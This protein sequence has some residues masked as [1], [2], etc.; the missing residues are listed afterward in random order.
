MFDNV[1]KNNYRN[2]S[3][4]IRENEFTFIYASDHHKLQLIN[5]LI[6][7]REKPDSGTITRERRENFTR[8]KKGG[9]QVVYRDQVLLLS[10]T[11]ADNLKFIKHILYISGEK[12]KRDIEEILK[13]VELDFWSHKKPSAL[14]THQLL[15]LQLARSL[16]FDPSFLILLDPTRKLSEINLRALENT[17]TSANI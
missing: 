4:C 11:V 3:F 8:K 1:S 9:I 14:M 12:F 5:R 17:P 10:R 15:R 16:I 2:I 6:S 7:G 13:L